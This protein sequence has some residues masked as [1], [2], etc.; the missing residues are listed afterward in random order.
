MC[1]T[2]TIS[3]YST[4][5]LLKKQH[6][7]ARDAGVTY[8]WYINEPS[9]YALSHVAA[10]VES[11]VL[12]PFVDMYVSY[13]RAFVSISYDAH[14]LTSDDALT[15]RRSFNGLASILSAHEYIDNGNARG[16]VVVTL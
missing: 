16:K 2:P 12:R 3:L 7:Y 13:V 9:H 11:R 1:H 6:E 10:L 8:N 14:Y 5:T 4:S 15:H